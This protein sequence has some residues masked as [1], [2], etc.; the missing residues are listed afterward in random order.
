VSDPDTEY[1]HIDGTLVPA[2]E[3]TVNVRDRGFAYADAVVER[4]RVYGGEP[5]EWAAH[6]DRL[7]RSAARLDFEEVLPPTDDLH[8]RV[9]DTA[10]ANDLADARV[11]L[12]VSRG[13]QDRDLTPN[14]RVDPTITVV[15]D[16]LPRGGTDGERAW[17]EPATLR[18]VETRR[19]PAGAIPADIGTHNALNGVLARLELPAEA[20]EALVRSTEGHVTGGAASDLFLV[21]SGTLYTPTSSLPVRSGVT[22]GVVLDIAQGESFPVET[23]RYTLVDVREA[24]E[25]FLTNPT[26]EV[27]PVTEV[28]GY[29]KPVGP[30][31]QLCQRLFDR[32]V[33]RAH[34]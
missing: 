2:A 28:D 4:L 16:D 29:E 14:P 1:C 15:I 27:R 24:D 6:V 7:R 20:D 9:T 25:L 5:F 33:E 22:R 3:A 18:A 26:W 31:T 21:H 17:D 23:G 19:P 8:D 12:S 32:R 10:D 11:R 13:I 30:I 34:Y